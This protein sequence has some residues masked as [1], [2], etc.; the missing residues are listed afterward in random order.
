VRVERC[1]GF[2]DLCGFTSFTERYGDEHTVV[3]LA[4]FRTKMREI[5]ARRGVRITKWLGDGAMLSS[6]EGEP[7]VS[8]MIELGARTDPRAVPLQIRGGLAL[9]PVIMFEGDDYIGRAINIA[10]RLCD[11]A[12]PGQVLGTREVVAVAPRWVA[13]GEP[14]PYEMQGFDRA[15][16]ACR[17]EIGKSSKTV[18]DSHCGLVIPADSY[19]ASRVDAD[20]YI[21]YFCSTACALAWELDQR[22]PPPLLDW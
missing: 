7:V 11:A 13:A 12:T 20:G 22:T 14:F 4:N 10:A 1:F 21:H 17:L 5:A 19:L 8:L 18:T 2:V 3:V 15:I 6:Q 16:D 9:G